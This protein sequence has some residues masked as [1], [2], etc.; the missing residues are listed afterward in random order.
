M[1]FLENKVG[2]V[3]I[4]RQLKRF[5]SNQDFLMKRLPEWLSVKNGNISYINNGIKIDGSV[6]K[7]ETVTF[8]VYNMD[9]VSF[10]LFNLFLHSRSANASLKL[11]NE[12]ESQEIGLY[13]DT[14]NQYSCFKII[15]RNLIGS[16][17]YPQFASD[18]VIYNSGEIQKQFN[19]IRFF[20]CDFGKS[21]T[22]R[23][24][25]RNIRM[26][27]CPYDGDA[28]ILENNVS[29][30]A[31]TELR[32]YRE[33]DANVHDP[34]FIGDIFNFQGNWKWAMESN[35]SVEFSGIEMIIQQSR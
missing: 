32:K 15:N 3:Q 19:R 28:Q 34:G 1:Y 7:F 9:M 8:Q 2:E 27:V 33:Y 30:Y 26:F 13:A 5:D 14:I 6:V 18:G 22:L 10:E 20:W 24:G 23:I 4:G 31:F 29:S 11:I 12:D 16:V 21:E 17:Q 25:C 35:G